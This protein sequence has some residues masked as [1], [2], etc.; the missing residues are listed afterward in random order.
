MFPFCDTPVFLLFGIYPGDIYAGADLAGESG[1]G[2]NSASGAFL[3][4]YPRAEGKRK[5]AGMVFTVWRSA[6]LLLGFIY[7][8]HAGTDYG[9][10]L[11]DSVR[12]W[13][14]R[15]GKIYKSCHMLHSLPDLCR[16]VSADTLGG[17][18]HAGDIWID[19]RTIQDVCG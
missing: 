9:G 8:N 6:F 11:R 4:V 18:I 12:N 13:R 2:G 1:T 7:G 16:N 3:S 15:S 10:D 5:S 14:Q 17:C 19:I